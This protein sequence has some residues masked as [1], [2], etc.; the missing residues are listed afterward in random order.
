MNAEGAAPPE[1]DA[2]LIARLMRFYSVETLEQLAIAQNRHV[3]KLQTY[4]A[5]RLSDDIRRTPREG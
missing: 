2:D 4:G 5:P 1:S 3:E